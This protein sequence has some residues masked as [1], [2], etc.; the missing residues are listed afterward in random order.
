LGGVSI[1][2]GSG[3]AHGAILGAILF[4]MLNNALPLLKFSPF[5]QE[6]VRGLVILTSILVNSLVQRRSARKA[7]EGGAA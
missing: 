7:L 4:G 6:A 1:S 3:K 5:W 2:G